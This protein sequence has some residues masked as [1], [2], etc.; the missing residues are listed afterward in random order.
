MKKILF[1]FL[2]LLFS[3]PLITYSQINEGMIGGTNWSY[4]GPIGSTTPNTGAFTSLAVGPLGVTITPTYG[5][6][7]I[8][9]DNSCTGWTLGAGWACGGDGTLLKNAAGTG[10]A[11]YNASEAGGEA[12]QVIIP[13]TGF[14]AGTFTIAI[15][16]SLARTLASAD[17]ATQ[18]GTQHHNAATTGDLTL[19]PTSAARFIIGNTLSVKK[20]TNGGLSLYND[21]F[22]YGGQILAQAGT[23]QLPGLSFRLAPTT[24]FYLDSSIYVSLALAGIRVAMFGSSF[25]WGP[26]DTYTYQFGVAGD[27]VIARD[28]ANVLAL[29]NGTSAQISRVYNTWTSATNNEKI[30]LDWATLANIP[31]IRVSAGSGGGT[32]RSVVGVMTEANGQYLGIRTKTVLQ[33]IATGTT[34][35]TWAGGIPANAQVIGISATVTVQPPDTLTCI[36]VS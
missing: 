22:M 13:I 29:R 5:A 33:T 15:G 26:S 35:S 32:Q 19:T 12:Y 6:E 11:V 23:R 28:A 34:T 31:L 18:T 36:L 3:V 10:T 7:K 30:S 1:A 16:G 14:S 25:L 2:I 8:T 4:P 9:I 24:G 17:G 27:L 21:L 20:M